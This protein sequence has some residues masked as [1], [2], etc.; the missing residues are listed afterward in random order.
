MVEKLREIQ[1]V[2]REDFAP[3]NAGTKA[4]ELISRGV[5]CETKLDDNLLCE[6][7]ATGTLDFDIIGELEQI[8]VCSPEHREIAAIHVNEELS[9]QGR[10][11]VPGYN[12]FGRN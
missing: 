8:P 2:R 6:Q 9:L 5:V 4:F 12:G 1:I 7:P 11:T 3:G 10:S